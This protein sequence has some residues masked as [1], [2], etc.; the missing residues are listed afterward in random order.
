ML[1]WLFAFLNIAAGN[2]REL[3]ST[4]LGQFAVKRDSKEKYF[5]NK[6]NIVLLYEPFNHLYQNLLFQR[7]TQ[8]QIV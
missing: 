8:R 6:Q 3:L 1:E 2:K 4:L 7:N 5:E